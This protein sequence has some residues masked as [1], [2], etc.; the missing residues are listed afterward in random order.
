MTKSALEGP[1]GRGSWDEGKEEGS[2]MFIAALFTIA[3]T[4]KHPSTDS[5]LKKMGYN[6]YVQWNITPP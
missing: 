6:I 3:K 5:W 1:T 2:E 4:W